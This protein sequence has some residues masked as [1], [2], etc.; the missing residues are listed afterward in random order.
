[1]NDEEINKGKSDL[2]KYDGIQISD[3]P[4]LEHC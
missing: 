4:T 1:M 3:K 2:N